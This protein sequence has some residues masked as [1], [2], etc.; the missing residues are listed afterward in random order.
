LLV[1]LAECAIGGAKPIGARVKLDQ[2]CQRLDGLLFGESQGRAL[3]STRPENA[4]NLLAMLSE[5]GMPAQAI[6]HVG[7]TQLEIEA[8]GSEFR[9]DIPALH[10]AWDGALAQHLS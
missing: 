9:W 2:P 7:G 3:L 1:A 5:A 10:A 6:G 4:A 8:A